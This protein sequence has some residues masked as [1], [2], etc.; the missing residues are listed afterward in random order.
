LTPEQ[1]AQSKQRGAMGVITEEDVGTVDGTDVLISIEKVMFTDGALVGV[2][3]L[4]S[5]SGSVQINSGC[6][7]GNHGAQIGGLIQS[8]TQKLADVKQVLKDAFKEAR[9]E[10]GWNIGRGTVGATGHD[11]HR[12]EGGRKD[13]GNGSHHDQ[14]DWCV[15]EAKAADP[16]H[17]GRDS[18][19]A[20]GDGRGGS[21]RVD[22]DD[23]TSRRHGS[24][25]LPI[26]ALGASRGASQPNIAEFGNQ[27]KGKDKGG[28]SR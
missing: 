26:G 27:T 24:P 28:K 7:A 1:I 18:G 8:F 15:S 9:D 13:H 4:S 17:A 14:P 12:D 20:G 16:G 22:W 6:D 3:S 2:P 25:F 5:L 23:D 21:G 10:W 11:S 19:H